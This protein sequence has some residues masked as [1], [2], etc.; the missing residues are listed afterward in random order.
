MLE[1]ANSFMTVAEVDVRDH[2]GR[3][4]G[5]VRYKDDG[6]ESADGDSDS[7]V[8]GRLRQG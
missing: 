1:D 2:K 4:D 5:R 8:P 6:K 3:R 7:T